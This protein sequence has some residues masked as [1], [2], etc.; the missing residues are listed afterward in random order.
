MRATILGADIRGVERK[1]G[2]AGDYL[3]VRFED[4]TGKP[5]D[6]CDKDVS[7]ESYYKKG[8]VGNIHINVDVGRQ[9]TTIRVVDFEITN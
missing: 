1:T 4:S 8:T 2:K 7:R 3:V 6:V 5:C 9:Y